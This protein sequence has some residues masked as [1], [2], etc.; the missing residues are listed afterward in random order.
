VVELNRAVA[1]AM[2]YG[3]AAG[4]ELADQ[5]AAQGSLE[6]YHLLPSVRGDLL[7]KLGRYEEARGEFERAATLTRNARETRCCWIVRR[8]PARRR[9]R[10]ALNPTLS[11]SFMPYMLLIVEPQGS[12]G[13]VRRRKVMR[14]TS[15]CS[16]T[17]RA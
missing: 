8:L 7:A 13:C 11:E 6:S 17:P 15:R 5:L 10:S 14:S 1:V 16:S 4:L 3:P 2:A 12:G 9:V